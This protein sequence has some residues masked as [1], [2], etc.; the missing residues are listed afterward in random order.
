MLPKI[1]LHKKNGHSHPPSA[2]A[3]SLGDIIR[4]AHGAGDRPTP[5]TYGV[6]KFA[7]VVRSEKRSALIEEALHRVD[8]VHAGLNGLIARTEAAFAR[9]DLGDVQE[10][11]EALRAQAGEA[12]Q[13]FARLLASAETRTTGHGL[14]AV[15]QLVAD[16][17][18]RARGTV[19]APL[20]IN[21][22]GAAPSILGNARRLE[23]ALMT[24]VA[25]LGGGPEV[26]MAVS[27][28]GGVIRGETIV[29]LVISGG[30]P[31]PAVA[32]ALGGPAPLADP[33]TAA[34]DVHLARQI[35]LEHGG[36][37]SLESGTNGDGV[38]RIEFPAV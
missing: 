7:T 34:L 4:Q 33:P 9:G 38:L 19:A 15:N 5:P 30:A 11:L 17:A 16:V 22:D 20:S 26:A 28:D 14:V 12:T 13:L 29:R 36:A 24:F 32:A 1:V 21:F 3:P 10:T 18:E 8:G 37:V 2:E 25:A 6:L 27:Q 35:V 31:L 23:R